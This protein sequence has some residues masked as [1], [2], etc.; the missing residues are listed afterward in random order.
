M[1]FFFFLNELDYTELLDDYI[2]LVIWYNGFT[3]WSIEVFARCLYVLR[4]SL[5]LECEV[6]HLV[7][8]GTRGLT[9]GR[10]KLKVSKG[11]I[12]NSYFVNRQSMFLLLAV[13]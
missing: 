13:T 2:C 5:T 9:R 11:L 12:E 1:N 10:Q 6:D 8:G 3:C 7:V 4:N